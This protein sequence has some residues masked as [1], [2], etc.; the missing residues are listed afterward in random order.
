VKGNA[1]ACS[2][3]L[4]SLSAF[5]R[6]A[7]VRG[8]IIVP[9]VIDRGAPFLR[10]S[11]GSFVRAVLSHFCVGRIQQLAAWSYKIENPLGLRFFGAM[12]GV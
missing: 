7:N 1:N 5:G 10:A 4:Q 6:D 2:K 8:S 3:L 9:L 11:T 12:S